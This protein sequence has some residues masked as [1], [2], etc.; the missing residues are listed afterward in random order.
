[1]NVVS[2]LNGVRLF[3]RGRGRPV[4][5]VS[6]LEGSGESCLHL[7]LPTIEVPPEGAPAQRSLLVNYSLEDHATFEGLVNTSYRLVAKEVGDADCAL[8]CQSFGNLL[9]TAIVERGPFRVQKT[10]LVSPFMRLPVWKTGLILRG[11]GLVPSPLFPIYDASTYF[12]GDWQFG[13]DGGNSMHPFFASLK[14][15]TPPTLARRAGWVRGRTFADNFR[16]LRGPRRAFLGTRD[17]LIDLEEQRLFFDSLAPAIGLEMIEGSGHVP[18]PP[19]V[20]VD[21]RIQLRRWFWNLDS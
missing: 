9:G 13:P 2:E 7:T 16:N 20:I 21:A 6:G 18:L 10:V 8:W 1:M 3:S 11:L 12:V 5:I 15:L 4:I 19:P 14:A 17:N